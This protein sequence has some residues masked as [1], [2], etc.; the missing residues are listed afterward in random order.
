MIPVILSYIT[1]YIVWGSTYFFIKAAVETIPPFYIVGIRFLAGGIILLTIARL[2]GTLKILPDR[3]AVFSSVFIGFLLLILGNGLVTV[4][5]KKVDSYLAA[6]LIATTPIMVLA[7]DRV[8]FRKE[9]SFINLIGALIGLG[10]V[11]LLLF[12]GTGYMPKIS[13]HLML[14]FTGVFFWS[15]GTAF[16]KRL[17]LPRDNFV[18]SGIQLI[19]VGFLTLLVL[20][21][22]QPVSAVAWHTTTSWSWL[23]LG[24]LSIFGTLALCSYAYLCTHEPNHRVVSYALVNPVIAVVI[25]LF[26]GG[27]TKVPFIIPGVSGILLGLFFMLYGDRVVKGTSIKG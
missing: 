9:V 27:E 18:N 24:F 8:L 14:I 17:P 4:A 5:E 11:A 22:I 21:F 19:T 2:R 26:L 13:L 1:V 7:I 25:G 3:K 15:L 12:D 16:A 20:Q 6:L 23:S 10:G